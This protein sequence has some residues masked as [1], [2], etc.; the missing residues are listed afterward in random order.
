M[1]LEQ[2]IESKQIYL[3]QL[4]STANEMLVSMMRYEKTA[5]KQRTKAAK[6]SL[7]SNDD[8]ASE[9]SDEKWNVDKIKQINDEINNLEMKIDYGKV[10]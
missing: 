1:V 7:S 8:T 5:Q 2:L 6:L 4:Q 9:E 10:S 3:A